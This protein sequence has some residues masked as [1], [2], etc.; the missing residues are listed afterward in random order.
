MRAVGGQVRGM[1]ER[2]E[3]E[4]GGWM[5]TAMGSVVALR[6]EAGLDVVTD[7]GWSRK[8]YPAA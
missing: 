4:R 3:A 6:E 8:S 1:G 7:G 5:D 2:E